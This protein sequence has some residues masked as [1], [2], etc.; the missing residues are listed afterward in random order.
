MNPYEILDVNTDCTVEEINISYKKLSKKYHP[1]MPNGDHE[2][3][4][5]IKLCVDILR[6][7]HKRKM[8][9]MH[10]IIID[11]SIDEFHEIVNNRFVEMCNSWIGEQINTKQEINITIYFGKILDN[12][13][14]LVKRALKTSEDTI[15]ELKKTEKRIICKSIDNPL[16]KIIHSKIKE[17]EVMI[18]S[19]KKDGVILDLLKEKTDLYSSNEETILHERKETILYGRNKNINGSVGFRE[20]FQNEF[21]KF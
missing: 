21:N 10:G 14:V 20:F 5:E 3:F 16:L 19:I 7:P 12:N 4:L 1:D 11:N 9:D 8:Y 18:D 15:K 2:K 13:K 17:Q 6:D